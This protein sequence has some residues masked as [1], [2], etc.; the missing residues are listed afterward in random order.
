MMSVE[1][2]MHIAMQLQ[3]TGQLGHAETLLN[4]LL[5]MYPA[6]ADALHL[7]GVIAYQVD[8]I[9]LSIQFIERAIQSNPHVALFYSNLGEM[10]RK[11]NAIPLSIRYG[12]QAVALD[13]HSATAL[14]NLGVAYYDAKDYTQAEDCHKRAL[15]INPKLS[16]SL[17]N[18]G[19][20]YKA[21]NKTE[22]AII[23]YQAAIASSPQ[24]VDPL[25]NVGAL[26]LLQQEFRQ[27]SKYLSQAII[28]APTFA[29]AHCNM[30]LT[31]LGLEQYDN[32]L[33][34]FEKALQLKPDYTE[35]Y[36]GI[37]KAHLH[38]HH[39]LASESALRKA[40]A[41]N[42]QQ[43]EFYQ[44]LAAIYQEQSNYKQALLYVDHALQI[45]STRA[46]SYLS[47][48]HVLMEMGEIIKAEEQFLKSATDPI[49]DTQ[50]LAHY[51]LV[52]L[53]KVKPDNASLNNLLS[54]INHGQAV[55]PS[56]LEYAYFA[57]GKCHDDMGEWSKAFE[58]F[59]LACQIKRTRITY[60]IAEQ[61]EFTNKLIQC[62]TQ[63]T[64]AYLQRFAN[65][66]ALPIFIVG[67]PRSGTTLVEHILSSHSH[68]YGAG[69]LKYL[70]NLIQQ[71]V[72]YHQ[73]TLYY[74]ENIQH[75]SPEIGHAIADNYI[76]HLQ[77]SSPLALRITDK[78]PYNFIAIG[79]I[80]ALFPN[81]KI[82][83][84]E[85]HPIDT[86]LSCYTKLFTQ[87]QLYSYDLTELGQYYQCYERI[88]DHWRHILP[89]NAWLDIKYETMVNHFDEEVTR[90][91]DFCGL[92]WEEACL[93]FYQSK[94]QV[95]TAS[96]AQVRQ[97]VYT[98][99]I[100]RWRRYERE[101]SPLIHVLNQ[102]MK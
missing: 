82:I 99:S 47:K 89:S 7:L 31:L 9:S 4:R 37:A 22:E 70:N 77:R 43:V 102:P 62:F 72:K 81:A 19:S 96:F 67:M 5:E 6:H 11:L 13:P 3:Q 101:L 53:R 66:S 97:P 42:P 2:T 27:A 55:S 60:D 98:S 36:Y 61:I 95:R 23:F 74:P 88:M 17:N 64:I 69:E 26:L 16:P 25:N 90:L 20:I 41:I 38:Q 63:Q 93:T 100:E 54:I 83:H 75:F 68:V 71:P 46:S 85:R 14:S 86:C 65:P 21:Y 32:A 91:I 58:Y 49:I 56:K 12:Q 51:S 30:G 78:M 33:L 73:T 94:R 76:S 80:H 92:P 45:D 59:S 40:I 87:G 15:A 44:L 18:M 8:K 50:V 10:H 1:E 57:L 48:G 34:H 24:F 39:F 29:D 84:V 52:Q 28:L 35:A 79:L